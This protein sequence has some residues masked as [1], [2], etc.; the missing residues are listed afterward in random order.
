MKKYILILLG[1][2]LLM[3]LNSCQKETAP[4]ALGSHAKQALDGKKV[5]FVGCS[6]TYYGNVVH[7][8]SMEQDTQNYVQ[9]QKERMNDQ[10][11]FYQ[12]CKANGAE[13]NVTDW[14]YG[15]HDLTDLFDGSCNADRGC[16]DHDHL[17]DLEDR[18]YD[19][20]ILQE[21]LVPDY[22]TAEDYLT[23]V[24][25]IM[26]VFREANPDV[27]FYYVL[28]DGI[29]TQD[30]PDYWKDAAELIRKEGVSILDWGTLVYDVWNGAV[31][32][33]GAAL[34]YNKQSFIVSRTLI[35]GYHPNPLSGYLYSLMAYC[36]ITGETAVN[37]PYEFCTADTDVLNQYIKRHYTYDRL[38]TPENEKETNFIQI[39]SSKADMKGLQ[40]LVDQYLG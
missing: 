36:A 12:L 2:L 23:N 29:Y 18:F 10:A 40:T 16:N 6:Y 19:Y 31:S 1:S 39:L 8:G 28:H 7:R 5:I 33:P 32:V 21:I 24:R 13:V 9:D 3:S 27:R 30:Y 38:T 34:S 35:D 14:C 20:V 25:N 15:G 17:R 22:K 11:F 4:F 37:Q 26:S